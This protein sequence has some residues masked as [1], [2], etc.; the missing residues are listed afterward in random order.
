MRRIS[1]RDLLPRKQA[2]IS[3]TN[4]SYIAVCIFFVFHPPLNKTLLIDPE[5]SVASNN[6]KEKDK[7][8]YVSLGERKRNDSILKQRSK[9]RASESFRCCQVPFQD[10]FA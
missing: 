5:G 2:F 8:L 10:A 4:E 7:L 3:W 9:Q 1:L 6:K